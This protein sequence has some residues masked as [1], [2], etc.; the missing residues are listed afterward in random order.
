MP[1]TDVNNILRK[2]QPK[3]GIAHQPGCVDQVSQIQFLQEPHDPKTGF[4]NQAAKIAPLSATACSAQRAG[5]PEKA[6]EG[7][8][9][10]TTPIG[11]DPIR[12]ADRQEV[13][14]RT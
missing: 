5:M 3:G 2:R 7:V 13:P 4:C 12:F 6:N 8:E 11:N 10:D 1:A 9:R 14:R